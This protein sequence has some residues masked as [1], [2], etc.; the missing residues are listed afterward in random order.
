M[1]VLSN[2]LMAILR[3]MEARN[4]KAPILGDHEFFDPDDFPWMRSVIA[5]A[6]RIREE[7]RAVLAQRNR[8]PSLQDISPE[9]AALT[10]DAGWKTYFL[11]MAGKRLDKN[12]AACPATEQALLRIPGMQSAFYS[13]LA[14]GKKL[15]PHRGPYNGILRFHL[16][17]KIPASDET[18]AIRVGSQTR[19]WTELEPMV[20]DDTYEHEAWNLTPEWRAVLFVDFKR[21]L[22]FPQAELNYMMLQ[23]I[24][25]TSF[26][27]VAA[28]NHTKWEK[29]FYD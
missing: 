10:T 17:L 22:R 1:S 5:D 23:L 6:P 15:P 24:F 26:V 3:R 25:R 11:Y 8:L 7:L 19:S 21:P 28:K 20:F 13:I 27:S 4:K 14:P 12:C 16:G 29:A 9:Q 2:G 18:C